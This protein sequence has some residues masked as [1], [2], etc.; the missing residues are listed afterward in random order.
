ME[1]INY[2]CKKQNKTVQALV[3]FSC[4]SLLDEPSL[5]CAVVRFHCGL[6]DLRKTN[7]PGF[8]LNN[9]VLQGTKHCKTVSGQFSKFRS[10]MFQETFSKNK[11]KFSLFTSLI[12]SSDCLVAKDSLI[13]R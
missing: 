1:E 9:L 8:V 5:L 11:L 2:T 10:N 13:F 6:C 3:L 4:F 12:C 7:R